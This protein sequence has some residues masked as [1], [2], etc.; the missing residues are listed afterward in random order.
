MWLSA[1]LPVPGMKKKRFPV[2]LALLAV[3]VILAIPAALFGPK[4]LAY[5]SGGANGY[6]S[7]KGTYTPG[8]TPPAQAH[9]KKFVSGSRYSMDYPDQ[10]STSNKQQS[11]QGQPDTID[12]F[13]PTTASGFSSMLVE[14]A[15]A[16]GSVSDQDIITNEV[17]AAAQNGV[18]FTPT[19][20]GTTQVNIGGEYWQR[21]DY[22]V[23]GGTSPSLH[24]AIL[25]GH[26]QGRSY[27]IVLVSAADSFASDAALYFTPA[28]TSF[29]FNG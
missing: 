26:H 5:V 16:A 19:S 6:T 27:V 17:A 15:T 21:R 23:T 12:I 14:Q 24:E 1:S 10:W 3:L 25:A 8:P 22:V 20:T 4:A 13:A 2:V 9:F 18:V 28:L 11:V 7:L 29:R